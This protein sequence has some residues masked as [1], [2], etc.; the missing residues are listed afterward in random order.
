MN[1]PALSPPGAQVVQDHLGADGSRDGWSNR[2]LH[3]ATRIVSN[4]VFSLGFSLRWE[5]SH[6]IPAEGPALAISNHQSYLDPP[7]IG[8]T[9][10]RRLVYLARASLFRN[11]VFGA[12]I[13]GLNAVPIDQDGV[14]KEGIKAILQQL[15][16][17]KTVL[18]FPEGTRTPD[19]TMQPLRPGIHL[20][21]KRTSAPIVPIGIAGAYDAW[22]LWRPY[23]IPSPIF[24][25]ATERTIAVS[26]G[27]PIDPTRFAAMPREV[28]MVELGKVIAEA[29]ERAERLRR[30]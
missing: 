14:G 13:R 15:L 18:V 17:G 20:L 7:A 16:A 9:T 8:L 6:N 11:P 2:L 25:P 1:R 22:P 29:K 19:G 26:I 23:P 21:I 10:P 3:V 5:G 4:T 30:K 12:L 24:L 27:R 28:A